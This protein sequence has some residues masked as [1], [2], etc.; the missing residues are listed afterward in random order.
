MTQMHLSK[1][2]K[3]DAV[4]AAQ[5]MAKNKK[6]LKKK[7]NQAHRHREQTVVAKGEGTGR[8][9]EWEFRVSR[10]KLY[11]EHTYIYISEPLCCTAEINT[12]L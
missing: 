12:T 4:G 5:E 2:E 6:K 8:G 7:R 3:S 9:I 1:R 10:Y 11:R